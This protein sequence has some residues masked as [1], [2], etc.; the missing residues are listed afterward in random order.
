MEY[1]PVPVYGHGNQT[2]N[3]DGTQHDQDRDG[4]ETRV[5]I[6]GQSYTRQYGERNCEQPNEKIRARQGDDV[7]VGP[8]AE[9]SFLGEDQDDEAVAEDGA[10]GDED[11]ADGIG[12]VQLGPSWTGRHVVVQAR[13]F[14]T[15]TDRHGDGLG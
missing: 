6:R 14:R 3:T 5:Q 2:K 1:R 15:Q 8:S 7:V 13:L 4:E 11:L 10:D 12:Q 9:L